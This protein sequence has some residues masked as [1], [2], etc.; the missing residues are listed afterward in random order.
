MSKKDQHAQ[1]EEKPEEELSYAELLRRREDEDRY[2]AEQRMN[3]GQKTG[4][5]GISASFLVGTFCILFLIVGLSFLGF[6]IYN[7]FDG[8]P[9]GMGTPKNIIIM[10]VL[11]VVIS[12]ASVFV[13]RMFHRNLHNDE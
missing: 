1:V 5:L 6:G 13:W 9:K 8:D 4:C 2:L 10:I 12:V 11:G 3:E 7:I